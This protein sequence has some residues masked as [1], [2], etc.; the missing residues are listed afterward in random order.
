MGVPYDMMIAS[1]EKGWG[2]FCGGFMRRKTSSGAVCYLARTS[3]DA[4]CYLARTSSDASHG[5]S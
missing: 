2:C 4:V 1:P 3:S 5:E